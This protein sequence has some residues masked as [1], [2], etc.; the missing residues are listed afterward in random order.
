MGKPSARVLEKPSA[1]KVAALRA[2]HQ[3]MDSP[4]VYTDPLALKILGPDVEARLR[5]NIDKYD[6]GEFRGLRTSLAVRSRLAADEWAV[7]RRCGVRQCVILGAGLDTFAYRPMEGADV[8]LFEVDLPDMQRWKRS[9]LRAAGI[10]APP[11]L[12]FVPLDFETDTL[13]AALGRAGFRPDEPAF[14]T[15][16]G[17]TM[18]LA[19]DAVLGQLRYIASLAPGSA[20]VFDYAVDP[21]LLSLAERAGLEALSG[22]TAGHGEEWKTF[23]APEPFAATLRTL[24]F[25][26]VDDLG[27]AEL[28]ARYLAGRTDGLRKSGVTRIICATV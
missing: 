8:R 23:F 2:V 16:L 13:A 24:G 20:V 11:A 19:A 12:S 4:P 14:F 28:N 6:T 5:A 21:D 7:A 9:R 26:R 22:R 27:A 18:Y 25:S 1:L 3:L 17:V 10:A 15:W